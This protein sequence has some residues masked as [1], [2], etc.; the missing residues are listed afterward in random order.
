MYIYI[1]EKLIINGCKEKKLKKSI[2]YFILFL[3]VS[4]LV[5]SIVKIY[6]LKEEKTFKISINQMAVWDLE[7]LNSEKFEP[8]NNEKLA[9]TLRKVGSDFNQNIISSKFIKNELTNQ[10]RVELEINETQREKLLLILERKLE[11]VIKNSKSYIEIYEDLK[12]DQEKGLISVTL[13]SMGLDKIYH[14]FD[15]DNGLI[16]RAKEKDTQMLTDNEKD[17]DV[18]K[19]KKALELNHIRALL[20]LYNN[21]EN[22]TNH[23]IRVEYINKDSGKLM[24]YYDNEKTEATLNTSIYNRSKNQD[25]SAETEMELTVIDILNENPKVIVAK[26]IRDDFFRKDQLVYIYF[27]GK[28]LPQNIKEN[29]KIKIKIPTEIE[30]RA[31]NLKQYGDAIGISSNDIKEIK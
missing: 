12:I 4:I 17:P 6:F 5:F 20:E 14:A 28:E 30:M 25:F 21:L 9:E 26:S 22:K 8:I 10:T 15:K 7:T 2:K 31:A 3:A 11:D 19:I 29:N 27:Y 24:N 18:I 23:N 1:L 16:D 13:D